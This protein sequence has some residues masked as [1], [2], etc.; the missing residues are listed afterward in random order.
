MSR[1]ALNI[2]DM[3]DEDSLRD[4]DWF[5]E[6]RD[7][8]PASEFTRQVHFLAA[9]K[10]MAPK[11]DALAVPNAGRSSDWERIRRHKEGA[12]AGALDLQMTWK[13]TRPDDR[14]IFFAEFKDGDGVPSKAQRERLN[15]YFRQGHKCGV[16]RTG[17]QLLLHLFEAG[18]P[19]LIPPQPMERNRARI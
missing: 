19:F 13:P 5:K 9:L 11:V 12:R 7:R 4:E 14:G 6:R 8:D 3:L 2:L 16:Y 17:A 18:A 15:L 10:K 1:G